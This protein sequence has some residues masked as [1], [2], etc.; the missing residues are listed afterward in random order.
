MSRGLGR[1]RDKCVLSY[2]V[3][4]EAVFIL[5]Y[6]LFCDVFVSGSEEMDIGSFSLLRGVTKQEVAK[7]GGSQDFFFV[8]LRFLNLYST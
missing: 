3:W 4:G 7:R 8:R 5:F 1:G 2:Y 6:F